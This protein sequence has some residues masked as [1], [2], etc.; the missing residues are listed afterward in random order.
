MLQLDL[1]TLFGPVPLGTVP[2][3]GLVS[4]PVVI[5]DLPPGLP[6]LGV[7]LQCAVLGAG[8][9]LSS[10]GHLTVLDSSY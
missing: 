8:T 3:G 10:W 7:Y 4:V 2:G 9:T 6:A 1:A 5:P